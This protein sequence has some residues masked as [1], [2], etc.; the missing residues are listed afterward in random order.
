MAWREGMFYGYAE[1]MRSADFL[2]A[3]YG[4][5]AEAAERQVAVMCS[6]NPVVAQPPPPSRGLRDAGKQHCS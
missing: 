5:L 1:H 6:E 2:A 4:V 3:I